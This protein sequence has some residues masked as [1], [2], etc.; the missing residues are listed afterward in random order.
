LLP[1]V[2][3]FCGRVEAGRQPLDDETLQGE[4]DWAVRFED[5]LGVEDFLLRR[6]D[7]GYGRRRAVAAIAEVVLD[8]L[9]DGLGWTTER[10]AEEKDLLKHALERIHG[11]QSPGRA[12]R[13]A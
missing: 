7:L 1:A 8:R 11:W 6:T 12:S 5:C 9:A 10:R 2:E 13:R 4:V 3:E